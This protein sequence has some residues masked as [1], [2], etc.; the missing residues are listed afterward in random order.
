MCARPSHAAQ[1]PGLCSAETNRESPCVNRGVRIR[2]TD[3]GTR[4]ESAVDDAA[5][6]RLAATG[7]AAAFAELYD[8]LAPM[9]LLRLRRRCGDA[10]MASDVLQETFVAVWRFADSFAGRGE[11]AAWVWTIAARKLIDAQRRLAVRAAEVPHDGETTETVVSAEDVVLAG[12]LDGPLAEAINR[13]SPELR[14]VLRATVLDGFTMAE[15]AELLDIPVGT[16][17]TRARRA[18]HTLREALT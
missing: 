12:A 3:R 9:V 1:A 16:V 14:A 18:R 8:R 10:S 11:V 13:L 6:L 7:D 5:L 2:R 17:K 4:G 15:T